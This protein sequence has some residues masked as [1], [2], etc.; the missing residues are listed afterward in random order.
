MKKKCVYESVANILG[1]IYFN[2][3]NGIT[4]KKKEE[5]DKQYDPSN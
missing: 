4:V 1:P 3:Y 5:M 2:D